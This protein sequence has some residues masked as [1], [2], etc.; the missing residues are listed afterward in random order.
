[1]G[2]IIGS[3]I[4]G[5]AFLAA[6]GIEAWL[7]LRR[8]Q[9]S[10]EEAGQDHPGDLGYPSGVVMHENDTQPFGMQLHVR[11]FVFISGLFPNRRR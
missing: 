1:M 3:V 2:T 8:R 11:L 4:G 9:R 5:L 7:F 6:V 10:G